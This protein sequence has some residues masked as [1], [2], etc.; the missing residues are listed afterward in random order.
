M[1]AIGLLRYA[2]GLL[3]RHPWKTVRVVGPALALMVALSLV[4][5]LTTPEILPSGSGDGTSL[6]VPTNWLLL[7]GLTVSYALMAILWHRHTLTGKHA[8]SAMT[9]SLV[10]SYLLR[11][12]Q[13]SLIQL[14]VSL[15]LIVPLLMSGQT[16]G[17]G[18]GGPSF[19]SV[20]LTTF[21]TQLL[22]VWLSLRLSLILPAAAI[23]QPIN[24]GLSW[25]CTK[26]LNHSLWQIAAVLAVFNTALTGTVSYFALTDRFSLFMIELPVYVFEGLLIF[27]ILT[28]LYKRQVQK[29]PLAKL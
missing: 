8:R 5:L 10:L 22:I 19:H 26:P 23:G 9:V 6:A 17:G 24:L 20:I 12:A 11:V 3:I 14:T 7:V 16:V 13:L 21:V 27:S 15:V 25:G 1:T 4:A 29:L 18:T 2:L 28:T